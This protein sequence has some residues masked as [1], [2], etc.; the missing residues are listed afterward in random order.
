MLCVIH[1][2]TTST[3]Y[4]VCSYDWTR[5]TQTC[6]VHKDIK[7][8]G[9]QRRY[10]IYARYVQICPT[11]NGRVVVI[12]LLNPSKSALLS[13]LGNFSFNS[14]SDYRYSVTQHVRPTRHFCHISRSC[15]TH[16]HRGRNDKMTKC[17]I[18]Q[19]CSVPGSQ[20]GIWRG[21]NATVVTTS[22]SREVRWFGLQPHILL[23]WP[24]Q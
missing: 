21:F 19:T 20:L 24:A 11:D 8:A 9:N 12:R 3:S 5:M 18:A 15:R 22:F 14:W 23:F 2:R 13:R 1:F 7:L 6:T 16:C 17:H 4:S 10:P